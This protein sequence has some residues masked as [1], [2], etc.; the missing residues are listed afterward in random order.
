TNSD[1]PT[2]LARIRSGIL[3][4]LPTITMA[5]FKKTPIVMVGSESS[6]PERMRAKMV[7][8]SEFVSK[9]IRPKSVLR[10]LITLGII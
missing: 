1:A 5:D 9:P 7:G 2:I 6:I 8:A 3:L 10:T 4:S